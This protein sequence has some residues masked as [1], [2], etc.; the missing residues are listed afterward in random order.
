MAARSPPEPRTAAC[1][2][3]I[4]KPASNAAACA[5]PGFLSLLN[6][7][8]QV[9]Y[10]DSDGNPGLRQ[11]DWTLKAGSYF[12]KLTATDGLSDCDLAMSRTQLTLS[13]QEDNDSR[14]AAMQLPALP[15]NGFTG[16]C[17]FF[18]YDGDVDDY[19]FVNIEAPQSLGASLTYDPL[20]GNIRLT[21]L[22]GSGASLDSD[23]SGN[24]GVR[25]V[26]AAVTPGTYYLR[27]QCSSGGAD[28]TM[29][30]S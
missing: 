2:S 19:Y 20:A 22:D 24:S 26:S 14:P 23:T 18:G 21:L 29:D 1:G 25:G 11:F 9:V 8:G 30:V 27:V 12:L 7:A 13:E 15:V 17:G 4:W 28:Y 16:H 10:D 5:A 6:S 3:G